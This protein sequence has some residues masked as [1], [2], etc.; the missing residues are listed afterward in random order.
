MA[1]IAMLSGGGGGGGGAVLGQQ[2]K[3]LFVKALHFLTC[4]SGAAW[5][6]YA[7]V[8]LNTHAK[9]S[10]TR[11]GLVR[12]A[13]L[14]SKLV[15]T[16]FWGAWSDQIDPK[17]LLTVSIVACACLFHFYRWDVVFQFFGLVLLLKVV[18]SG[19]NGMGTLV[20]IL[21]LRLLTGTPGGSA[22]Y[23]S[24]RLWTAVA[25]GVGSLLAGH[26]IDAF[27]FDAIWVW[28]YTGTAATLLL[29][30]ACPFSA[31]GQGILTAVGGG[32]GGGNAGSAG[33]GG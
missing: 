31:G 14:L 26:A 7:P 4:L 12:G 3:L 10:P 27:G 9:L 19:A 15:L 20:D 33:S 23:G 8:Y 13:G 2:H 29:L 24:Q 11:N 1:N 25:W 6:R 22:G 5:G 18:R 17:Q 30:W 32:G 28:Y 16:P 21:T